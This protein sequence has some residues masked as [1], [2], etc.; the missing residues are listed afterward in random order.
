MGKNGHEGGK[1]QAFSGSHLKSS[2][3]AQA[4]F[5]QKEGSSKGEQGWE[6]ALRLVE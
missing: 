6:V 3:T 1:I 4:W 2:A 5:H